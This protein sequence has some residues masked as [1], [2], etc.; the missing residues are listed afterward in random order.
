[1]KTKHSGATL[2]AA[3]FLCLI[4]GSL[5]ALS[6]ASP[7]GSKDPAMGKSSEAQGLKVVKQELVSPPFLPKHEQVA[8]GVPRIVRVELVVEEKE[9]EIDRGVFVQAR[10]YNGSIPGPIIV[11]HQDDYVEVTLI[12]PDTN[13][14]MHNIDFHAATGA[15]GG[16]MLTQVAP[17]Q[18][19]KLRFQATKAGVFVYHCAPGGIMTPWH[20]VSGMNGAIMVLPRNG[21][22]DAEG[23]PVRYNRAFY[24]GEQDFYVPQDSKGNHKRYGS[25][26]DSLADTIKEMKTLTPTHEVFNG[27]VNALTGD[28]ALLANVGETVLLIH[29]QANRD[30]RPHLIGGHADLVW[31]GGSFSSRPIK[32]QET[33]FVPGGSAGA[34]L[35]TFRQPGLYVYLNHNLIESVLLGALAHLQVEGNWNEDLMKQLKAPSAIKESG[36]GKPDFRSRRR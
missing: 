28:R 22:K 13:T 26:M 23:N 1:M 34:A 29:S 4:A 14:M 17:G 9:I 8:Q 12:N 31:P 15:M 21:L 5:T 6:S 20:V 16:G 33:W 30:T 7:Q 35:Y 19:V 25:Q 10:R 3:V 11:V 18:S 36:R 27:A 32:D 24:I 2:S